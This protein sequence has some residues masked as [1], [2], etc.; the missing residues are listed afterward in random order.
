MQTIF[1]LNYQGYSE[2]NRPIQLS[3]SYHTLLDNLAHMFFSFG[4]LLLITLTQT[5]LTEQF[6]LVQPI[7]TVPANCSRARFPVH[8]SCNHLQVYLQVKWFNNNL[9]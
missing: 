6:F 7:L 1:F 2:C 4:P 5:V 3:K 8:L 9:R